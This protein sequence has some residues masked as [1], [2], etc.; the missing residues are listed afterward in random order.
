MQKFIFLF[1]CLSISKIL[2]AQT[3]MPEICWTFDGKN[4]D[5]KEIS[6][7]E[8]IDEDIS[9]DFGVTQA[10]KVATANV[11][12]AIALIANQQKWIIIPIDTKKNE[13]ISPVQ[14]L[15]ALSILD[16][17]IEQPFKEPNEVLAV[18][19]NLLQKLF[20]EKGNDI[21]YKWED[22]ELILRGYNALDTNTMPP[23]PPKSERIAAVTMAYF[24][25]YEP[26]K[27]VKDE[28]LEGEQM[29]ADSIAAAVAAA[30][31]TLDINHDYSFPSDSAQI[32]ADYLPKTTVKWKEDVYNFKTIKEGEKVKH[33]FEV[34]NTGKED[35]HITK[36]K[37]SC[38]CTAT[39]CSKNI[40]KPGETCMIEIEFNS[41][42][43]S[44]TQQKSITVTGN[45]EGGTQKVLKFT[46][47][48]K[49]KK[50]RD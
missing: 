18:D 23:Y 37:P 44:G 24:S 41:A 34:K 4:T 14:V 21:Q 20:F 16:L 8:V 42:G 15:F 38:G 28:Y 46:G 47:D 33:S 45:F 48:V 39:Y 27:K 26:L 25:V 19:R 6:L 10:I 13:A 12:Q 50:K 22:M 9:G 2:L 5:I 32:M 49:S 11:P 40:I 43:K 17:G 3:L 1:F 35:L 36:V 31:A 29:R 30:N 7:T